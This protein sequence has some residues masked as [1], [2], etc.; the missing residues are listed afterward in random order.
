MYILV[1]LKEA[2]QSRI[3]PVKW[4]QGFTGDRL[5]KLLTNG[6]RFYRNVFYKVFYSPNINDEPD[7]NLNLQQRIVDD[8]RPACYEAAVKRGFGKYL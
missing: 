5:A 2:A 8:T 4:I 3:V 6:S 1:K 7:F